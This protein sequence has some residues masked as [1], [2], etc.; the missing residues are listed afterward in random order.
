MTAPGYTCYDGVVLAEIPD[1]GAPYLLY[2][3]NGEYKQSLAE[4]EARFPADDHT[5]LGVDVTGAGAAEAVIADV[6][7]GDISAESLETWIEQWNAGNPAYAKAGRPVVYC[8]RS[9]IP[10]V[11]Q[12]TGKYVLG[13]DYYLWISTLDGTHYTG[14]GVVAC[15]YATITGNA[16]NYDISVIYDT[17]FLG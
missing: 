7:F 15:Q 9:T 10:A 4:V 11:R 8:A 3:V 1:T 14:D 13:K 6:E 17:V 5:L 16:V 12:G 2:Y